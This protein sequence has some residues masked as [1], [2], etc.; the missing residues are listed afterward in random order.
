MPVSR[1][2]LIA[3]IAAMPAAT[4]LPGRFAAYPSRPIRLIAA[5]GFAA[6]ISANGSM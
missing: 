3:G 5:T 4:V 6:F 2:T 1:R